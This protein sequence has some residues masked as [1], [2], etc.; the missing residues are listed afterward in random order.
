[1]SDSIVNYKIASIDAWRNDCGG[2]DWYNVFDTG[3]EIELDYFATNRKILDELRK[4]EV[5][6]QWSAGKVAVGDDADDTIEILCKGD[7]SPMFALIPKHP[8]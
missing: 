5:L 8:I 3:M 2:W 6:S 1:M 4:M 7:R